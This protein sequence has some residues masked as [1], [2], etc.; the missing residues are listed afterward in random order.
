MKNRR[1]KAWELERYLLGEL[2]NSRIEEIKKLVQEN[3]EIKKDIER[4]KQSNQ[5]ILKQY[6]PE[7]LMPKILRLYEEE[8]H[9]EKIKQRTRPITLKRLLYA[10]PVLATALVIL[11]VV[12]HNS[13]TISHDTR[14]KGTEEID[15]TKPQIIMYKKNNDKVELVKSGDQARAGDLLQ[16][17]Y[18][19]AGKT[20]GV[21][22]SI[23]G[24]G[25]V[26]LHYPE[27]KNDPAILSQEKKYLLGIAYELDDAPEF[28]CFFF[29]TAMEE[30][31]VEEILE[32]AAALA[33]SPDS[34]KKKS[35]ELPETF[36]QFSLLLIKGEGQ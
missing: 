8:K 5:N 31:N 15:M 21:I 6:P 7:S 2:P 11:F 28:E 9:R 24:N 3:P 25:V 29:I 19:P 23:D 36:S 17:A 18:V 26:T 10:S 4:I 1:I 27:N 12:F 32:R 33:D 13:G 22:L 14:I 30:I 35:L 16:I 20:Y 34:A